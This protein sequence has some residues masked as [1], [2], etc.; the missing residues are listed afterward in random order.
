MATPLAPVLRDAVRGRVADPAA[1]HA[2]WAHAFDDLA[3]RTASLVAAPQLARALRRAGAPET[4]V[5][6]CAAAHPHVTGPEV[7]ATLTQ[8]WLLA[9][10]A[11]GDDPRHD[12]VLEGARLLAEASDARFAK[13]QREE[14]ARL[15][16]LAWELLL[17]RSLHTEGTTSP[18]TTDVDGWTGA[19]RRTRVTAWLDAA[20]PHR[21]RWHRPRG[22]VRRV[23]IVTRSG[24]NFL[25][26]PRE[27][28]AAAGVELREVVLTELQGDGWVLPGGPALATTRVAAREGTPVEVPP[29]LAEG[30]AWADQV[31]V[32]WC[33]EAAVLVS[34]TLPR[35]GPEL[36]VRLHSVE[37]LSLHP[38]FVS[39]ERVD[40]LAF[41][42]DHV[43][44]L[45]VAVLPRT[46][47]VRSG[48]L[49]PHSPSAPLGPLPPA[50]PEHVLAVVGWAQP[51]KDP[52]W[53]LDVLAALRRVDPRWRL[54]LVGRDQFG[55]PTTRPALQRYADA[56][57]DRSA[58]PDVAGA[59]EHLPWLDDVT[60]LGQHAGAVLSSSVREG[61]AVGLHEAVEGG[62]LPVVRRWPLLAPFGA[63]GETCDPEWVVD[64]PEQAAR[65]LLDADPSARERAYRWL[66]DHLGAVPV[67]R[68]YREVLRWPVPVPTAP[69]R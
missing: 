59:V 30:Y 1:V 43:A 9:R 60:T 17:D 56:F 64:T 12:E 49:P 48:L 66:D 42:C 23:L 22:R 52:L 32:D 25:A 53:A 47:R 27:L 29:A 46:A 58:E 39:W 67:A 40:R 37:A 36:V 62:V 3:T 2:A 65:R 14:A 57:R 15:V 44:Q 34:A 4:A 61:Y 6:L 18:L 7:R 50:G 11:A 45:L 68:A 28:A 8:A 20:K 63:P 55:E 16:H 24:S 38:H 35:G 13:E 54:L 19:V 33:D 5:A 21:P 51:V 31:L 41:V 10:I 26:Q 69:V